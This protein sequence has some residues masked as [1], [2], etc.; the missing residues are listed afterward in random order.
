MQFAG[1][2]LML[3]VEKRR[4]AAYGSRRQAGGTPPT[5]SREKSGDIYDSSYSASDEV[6]E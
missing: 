4:L 6:N 5:N 3:S 1:F 2:Y